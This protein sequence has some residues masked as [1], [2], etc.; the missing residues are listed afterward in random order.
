[1]LVIVLDLMCSKSP[2]RAHDL[3]SLSESR[4]SDRRAPLSPIAPAWVLFDQFK[5]SVDMFLLFVF[6]KTLD[7]GDQDLRVRVERK[8]GDC[9]S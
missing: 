9:F 3:R 5:R 8:E 2:L 4:S 1:M 6:F 7:K